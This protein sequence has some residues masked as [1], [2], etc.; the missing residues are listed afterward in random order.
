MGCC[1]VFA[2]LFLPLASSA[3]EQVH[4]AKGLQRDRAKL[5]IAYANFIDHKFH[6]LNASQIGSALVSTFIDCSVACTKTVSCFSFNLAASPDID[7]KL[8]CELLATD[9]YNASDKFQVNQFFHHYSIYVSHCASTF[10]G[11]GSLGFDQ[12]QQSNMSRI[13]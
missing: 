2:I 10:L 5:G 11:F 9:K 7:G 13:S 12:N 4:Y 6:Y 3:A 1:F 8:W